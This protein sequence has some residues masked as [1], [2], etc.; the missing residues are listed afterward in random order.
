MENN[1]EQATTEAVANP[2]PMDESIVAVVEAANSEMLVS[3]SPLQ[4][5]RRSPQESNKLMQDAGRAK[6]AVLMEAIVPSS[7]LSSFFS[8]TKGK[9]VPTKTS[10]D[11]P[12]YNC[13]I[14]LIEEAPLP[15][16]KSHMQIKC[17]FPNCL[18]H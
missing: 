6:Q 3:L 13:W 1:N 7:S 12:T 15:S 5:W 2:A 9:G 8:P 16:L 10:G 11:D 4:K 14:K 17:S 18:L